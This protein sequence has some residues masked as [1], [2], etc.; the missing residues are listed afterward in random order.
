MLCVGQLTSTGAEPRRSPVCQ[1]LQVRYCAVRIFGHSWQNARMADA[2][3]A[4]SLSTDELG[5]RRVQLLPG[6]AAAATRI[7]DLTDGYR[8]TFAPTSGVLETIARVIDAERQ[9]CRFLR[10]QLTCEQDAAPITLDVT[11]PAGTRGFLEE[12]LDDVRQPRRHEEH[13]GRTEFLGG[14][15]LR[16]PQSA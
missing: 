5:A 1:I 11:G 15:D 4:C 9:C 13:G 6:L 14:S 8:L 7:D 2:P 12:L 16:K 10:F 3:I